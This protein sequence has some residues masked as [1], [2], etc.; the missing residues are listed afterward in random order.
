M[1]EEYV[2]V[3][4]PLPQTTNLIMK[5]DQKLDRIDT[6]LIKEADKLNKKENL[7]NVK[8]EY[9]EKQRVGAITYRSYTI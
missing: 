7:A 8:K 3:L 4:I 5:K 2:K 1:A 9:R 6:K